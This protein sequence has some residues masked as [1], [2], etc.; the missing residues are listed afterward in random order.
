MNY[1]LYA[2]WIGWCGWSGWMLAAHGPKE[3]WLML[4]TLILL[5]AANFYGG[6]ASRSLKRLRAS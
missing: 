2:L 6:Y 1:V 5:M 3:R 4:A